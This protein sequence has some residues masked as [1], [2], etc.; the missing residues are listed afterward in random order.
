M[1]FIF[2]N[3]SK[4]NAQTINKQPVNNREQVF[5]KQTYMMQYT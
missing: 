2:Y 5:R 1:R 4:N 3:Y